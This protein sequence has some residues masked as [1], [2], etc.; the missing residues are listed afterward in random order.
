LGRLLGIDLGTRRIGL[1][2][3]DAS[4]LISSPFDTLTYR[5]DRD[6][7]RRL[8]DL[9]A[10]HDVD[11]VVIGL[12]L[13]EDGSEGPG[14]VRARQIAGL[15]EKR[16]V[17]AVLWDERWS[18]LRAEELLREG[19]LDRRRGIHKIDKVAASL[20]LEDYMNS[21]HKKD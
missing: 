10:E 13:R 18:S 19:G 3:S 7:V 12:P 11:K 17:E 16:G 9:A 1:A 6:L 20:I 2:L 8:A 4:R 15:L 5:G 21:T 14:C